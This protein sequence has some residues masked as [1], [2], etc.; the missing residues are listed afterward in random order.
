[1]NYAELVAA[2]SSLAETTFTTTEVDN[3]IR[4]TEILAYQTVDLL[5]MEAEAT[6]VTVSGTR[7]VAFPTGFV[8]PISLAVTVSSNV[9]YLLEKDVTFIRE[10]YPNPATTG[11]PQHYALYDTTQFI[12]G[13]TP[14]A[15]YTVNIRYEKYPD[16]IVDAGTTWLGDNF[17]PILLNGAMVQVGRF[18]KLEEDVIKN[19]DK[20]YLQSIALLKNL[21]SGKLRQDMYR[22]GYQRVKVN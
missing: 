19:Y 12:L 13:P 16:S 3:F 17:D 9:T 15:I 7:Y 22:E 4:Q 21:G 11:V 20:L 5:P 6:D 2:I 1:L 10:A 14:G 18:L 8:S